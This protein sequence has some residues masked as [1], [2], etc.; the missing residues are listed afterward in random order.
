LADRHMSR[1]LDLH[2]LLLMTGLAGLHCGDCLQLR[3]LGLR[4]VDAVA[5]DARH[6]ARVVHPTLPV[7]VR[8]AIVTGQTGRA[9]VRGFQDV[10]TL[11][12]FLLARVD[13]LLPRSMAGLARLPGAPGWGA[14]DLGVAVPRRAQALALG[15]VAGDAGFV[16]NKPRRLC[17]DGG[18]R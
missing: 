3:L 18:R 6:V 8:A 7:R 5:G 13:V 2:R 16:A 4:A 11:D 14:F 9:G 10:E 1:L 15:V 17:G 12:V